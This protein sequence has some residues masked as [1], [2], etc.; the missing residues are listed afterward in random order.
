MRP[1]KRA[2]GKGRGRERSKE[3]YRA[4]LKKKNTSKNGFEAVKHFFG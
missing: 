4:Q 1:W 2:E 3:K